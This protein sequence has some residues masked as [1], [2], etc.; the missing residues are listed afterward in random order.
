M[1]MDHAGSSGNEENTIQTPLP[2]EGKLVYLHWYFF[3]HLFWVLHVVISFY[4]LMINFALNIIL[5]D[6]SWTLNPL[7]FFFT[8]IFFPPSWIHTNNFL[9]SALFHLLCMMLSLIINSHTDSRKVHFEDNISSFLSFVKNKNPKPIIVF[10][11]KN[12]LKRGIKM[13]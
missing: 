9:Q 8:W 10:S 11:I 2:K 6:S 1:T 4:N 13:T 5:V 12:N 3:P 7:Q